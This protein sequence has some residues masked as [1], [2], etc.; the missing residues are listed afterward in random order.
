MTLIHFVRW[1]TSVKDLEDIIKKLK[2]HPVMSLSIDED[3]ELVIINDDK[4][5]EDSS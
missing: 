4:Q 3:V 1:T 5:K 2:E